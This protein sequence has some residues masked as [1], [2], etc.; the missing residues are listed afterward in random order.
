MKTV[1]TC[2]ITGNL[3]K[4]ENCPP[5]PITP[6][7]IAT[8][9]LDASDAGAAV[10]H[11]H[12]RD[13]D[14]GSPSMAVDLY[15]QVVSLIRAKNSDLI[16]NLTTGPGGRYHPQANAPGQPGERTN[17]L[18]PEQRVEHVVRIKPDI[19]TLDLNT[20]TF[21]QEVVTNVPWSVRRM[22]EIIYDNGVLPE[23]ELFDTGDINLMHDVLQDGSLNQLLMCSIVTGVEYGFMSDPRTL[24][25]AASLLPSNTFWTGFGV[26]GH[27]FPMLVQS[28]FLG[29][30][31]RVWFEDTTFL[32]KGQP[33][34][35]NAEYVEK[36]K[37]LIAQP[38]GEIATAGEARE[39][40]GLTRSKRGAA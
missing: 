31:A 20:M 3:T 29:G 8:S 36:A 24:A 9:A 17:L 7:Q 18:M 33:A 25:F 26:G 23:I 4:P 30:H 27:S 1:I 32:N 28:W 15:E 6:E 2:A 22:S 35:T 10:A 21:G 39:L 14:T 40:L 5:L 34:K 37:H 19:Y 11:I 12:V 16:I 38:S 13:P